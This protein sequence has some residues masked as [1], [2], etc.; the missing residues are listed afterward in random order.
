M[1][2]VL[3]MISAVIALSSPVATQVDQGCLHTRTTETTVQRSRREQ[4]LRLAQMINAAE[5]GG[6]ALGPYVRRPEYRPL[7]Q[8]P[9]SQATPAGFRLQFHTD[10]ASYSF[11]IKD[12]TDACHYAIFSDQDRRI[13]EATPRNGVYVMPA[14][15]E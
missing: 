2:S 10:G 9:I 11:S 4:A 8:L 14:E 6:P 12:I 1:R 3:A 7:D 13:Y 15:V 5:A